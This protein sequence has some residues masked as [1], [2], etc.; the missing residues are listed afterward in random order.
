[1]IQTI[2]CIAIQNS[3][4]LI[5][6]LNTN[7]SKSNISEITHKI[8]YTIAFIEKNGKKAHIVI[9]M[10]VIIIFTFSILTIFLI[11]ILSSL[12]FIIRSPFKTK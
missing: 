2:L 4:H 11:A 8:A 7:S 3:G 9:K 1:M 6:I 10:R 12:G 5:I